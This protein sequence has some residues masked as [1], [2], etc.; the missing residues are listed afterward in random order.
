MRGVAGRLAL[1]F[2][3]A[4]CG[5]G[6][7]ATDATTLSYRLGEPD[8]ALDAVATIQG[9]TT[10]VDL[11]L[12]I[13]PGALTYRPAAMG[14]VAVAEWTLRV[15]GA[16]LP[17]FV[18]G[19]D[20][21]RVADE[22]GARAAPP[23]VV[24][25][26]VGRSPGAYRAEAT[27]TDVQGDRTA[28]RAEVVVVRRR[29]DG[30][31]LS[32]PVLVEAGAGR[33]VPA[34]RLPAG[35]DSLRLVSQ[36]TAVPDSAVVAVTVLRLPADTS[37]ADL[38]L[39][40]TPLPT[41]LEARGV[42]MG[43]RD[44]V[45][46]LRQSVPSGAV[47]PVQTTL[48]PL[49]PGTFVL[50]LDLVGEQGRLLATATRR[51]VVRRRDFP[52]VTRVG[53]LI[54]PLVYLAGPDEMAALRRGGRRAFDAF[55]GAY[56]DD[57]RRATEALRTYYGRVEEA[58]RLFSNQKEGWKTDPGALYVLFGPPDAVRTTPTGEV[59]SYGRGG[60]APSQVA[61]DRTAGR[62]AER[63]PFAVLTLR[64]DRRYDRAVRE[65]RASWRAGRVP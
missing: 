58:N 6:G 42:G 39:E 15:S 35:S 55:W 37:V 33:P 53:D 18:R 41:S 63:S 44:T 57:R 17:T 29:D 2:L 34:S 9:D 4:G 52:L 31:W 60:P 32:D 28:R 1:A 11:V 47:L 21:L 36:A 24:A 25:R 43:Q 16:T 30:P 51:V 26:R 59:W 45:A 27:V 20:T 3:L 46:V 10:G 8:V 40:S 5:G 61:F 14:L 56:T 54:D 13:E 48:P 7:V 12:L 50:R 19:V 38:A 23:L 64:R 22:A 65:A 62:G 49:A